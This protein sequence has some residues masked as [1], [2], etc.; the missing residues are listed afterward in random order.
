MQ[1]QQREEEKKKAEQREKTNYS[2]P[3]NMHLHAAASSIQLLPAP[4]PGHPAWPISHPL[5]PLPG[6]LWNSLCWIKTLA[7]LVTSWVNLD[8]LLNLTKP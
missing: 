6:N 3:S 2:Q 7:L 5:M 8:Q 4:C 1:G